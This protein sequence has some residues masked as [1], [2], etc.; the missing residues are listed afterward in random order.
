MGSV[1]TTALATT[2][3]RT[4]PDIRE[5][6]TAI[7]AERDSVPPW[8]SVLIGVTGIDGSGKGYVTEK[9]VAQLQ[10][11]GVRAVPINVDGWLN[12][13]HWRFNPDN[14]AEHFYRHAIRFDEMFQQLI[15]PLKVNRRICL[16]ADFTEETATGYR[17]HTYEF[18]DVDVIV[19]EGIFLL[20]PAYRRH[21]DLSIW[22]DCTFE[23]ALERAV[24]RAQEG[25]PPAEMIRAYHTTYFPAQKI[26]M[27]RH[28]PRGAADLIIHNDPRIEG[29]RTRPAVWGDHA[30]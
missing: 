27:A 9:I 21:F 12:L 28:N 10:D 18:Q 11:E 22:V 20:K 8:R 15:L 5:A 4:T 13:P 17:K 7:R 26:H 16:V 1:V 6:V 30:E 3:E 29:Q 24:Q 25:L 2:A 19:L 14:P 23:T